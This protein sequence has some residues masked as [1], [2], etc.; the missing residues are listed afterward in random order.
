MVEQQLLLLEPVFREFLRI[1]RSFLRHHFIFRTSINAVR[2]TIADTPCSVQTV[3]TTRIT[4]ETGSHRRSSVQAPIMVSINGSGYAIGSVYFQ[5]IDL[6]S[7]SWTWGGEEP[8][9][10]GTLVIIENQE[11][12]YLDIETPILKVLVID[13][14]TLIFD[15]FQN[16]TLNVEYIVL[17]NGGHLIVGTESNPF[18]HRGVIKMYGH[19]RSIELPICK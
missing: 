11:T 15:D 17:V 1:L 19:L 8:P 6:W 2:V 13:N 5:Y 9:E 4:C 7:S 3:A 14:A 16:V 12:I 18:Q 10:A